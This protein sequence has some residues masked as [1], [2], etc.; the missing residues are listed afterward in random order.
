MS[1]PPSLTSAN[2]CCYRPTDE[3]VLPACVCAGGA[4]GCHSPALCLKVGQKLSLTAAVARLTHPLPCAA[5]AQDGAGGSQPLVALV[6]GPN[7]ALGACVADVSLCTLSLSQWQ[8]VD[9]GRSML[10]TLLLQANPAEVVVMRGGQVSRDTAR[11]LLAHRPL[12]ADGTERWV[13]TGCCGAVNHCQRRG[14]V[15]PFSLPLA[16]TLWYR[17]YPGTM[18]CA[19]FSPMS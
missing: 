14:S 19:A 11:L 9:A 12:S 3:L 6:E 5:L 17:A 2:A 1:L 15:C 13:C 10:G 16:C 8:E 4:A 7:G 18:Q